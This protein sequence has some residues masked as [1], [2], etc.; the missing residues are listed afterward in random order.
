M[1]LPRERA[2]GAVR[3][4]LGRWTTAADVDRAAAALVAAGQAALAS[5]Q[6]SVIS[7]QPAAS[8]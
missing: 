5:R 4:S 3:L 8:A 1:G 2:L 7:G 6:P